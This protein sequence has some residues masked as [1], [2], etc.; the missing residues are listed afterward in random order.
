MTLLYKG[1][2]KLGVNNGIGERAFINQ[3]RRRMMQKNVQYFVELTILKIGLQFFFRL[4]RI[5]IRNRTA[6]AINEL[7]SFWL[8]AIELLEEEPHVEAATTAFGSF[9]IIFVNREIR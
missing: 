6:G 3:R 7:K 8:E 2:Y 1:L 5:I 4:V 9:R